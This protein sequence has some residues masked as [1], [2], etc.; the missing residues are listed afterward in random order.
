MTWLQLEDEMWTFRH[1]S[2]GGIHDGMSAYTSAN[3]KLKK[4]NNRVAKLYDMSGTG[5]EDISS[6]VTNITS[7]LKALSKFVDDIADEIKTL[8][9]DFFDTFSNGPAQALS[10]VRSEDIKTPNTVGI[11]HVTSGTEADPMLT[12]SPPLITFDD[13]LGTDGWAAVPGGKYFSNMLAQDYGTWKDQHPDE[14]VSLD[15]YIH[16]WVK[17]GEYEHSG[18]HPILTL[19]TDVADVTVIWA[20]VKS[21]WGYDPIVQEHLSSEK[22]T[23]LMIMAFVDAACYA[24]ALPSGGASLEGS[25]LIRAA[26]K[27][28]LRELIMNA[29][30]AGA[31]Q[32]TYNLATALGLPS[33]LAVL[34]SMGVGIVVGLS[35]DGG[36]YI[37]KR[38]D[39]NGLESE[40]GR[41]DVP[42]EDPIHSTKRYGDQDP[43]DGFGMKP[44]EV[45]KTA[46]G[47]PL[48]APSPDQIARL[49]A[50]AA[51]PSSAIVKIDGR[52][53]LKD[54]IVLHFDADAYF[55][56][57]HNSLVKNG[58]D[59]DSIYKNGITYRE[60]YTRQLYLQQEGLNDLTVGEW[61]YNLADFAKNKRIDPGGQ[62][63]KARIEAKK[64]EL[65]LDPNATFEGTAILH[66]PDQVA[67]GRPNTFDGLGYGGINSSIGS[68]WE[69]T[70]IG[71]LQD[72]VN[73]AVED[74]PKD[75]RNFVNMNVQLLPS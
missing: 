38:V 54:T 60:E 44:G 71:F 58:I 36:K 16:S 11:T 40:I 9:H 30:A 55:T 65:K 31:A 8:D 6:Q 1:T 47:F 42:K 48:E 27:T 62:Q 32:M 67:G 13:M 28:G 53:Y 64:D 52:Y 3:K 23:S 50:L 68:Q 24:M 70:Q 12:S 14:D 41:I 29:V 5:W 66:G 33:G 10:E 21:V 15:E 73:G 46:R 51:D 61:Q 75:L 72:E 17:N 2:S 74:I 37:I 35:P 7:H 59:P 56:D 63:G 45:K 20:V 26:I 19:A 25:A 39:N 18:Y 34:L 22:R 57:P 4:I 69:K 49:D 43:S